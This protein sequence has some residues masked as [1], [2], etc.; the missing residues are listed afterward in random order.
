MNNTVTDSSKP[1]KPFQQRL[2]NL[3]DE[4][5]KQKRFFAVNPDKTPIPK[6]WSNPENQKPYTEIQ[7]YAGFDTTGHDVADD[8]LFLDFDH[9]FN[10]AGK[11][12]NALAEEWYTKIRDALK[13]Y[14]ELSISLRGAHMI[15]IPTAGKFPKIASGKNGRID[16]GDGACLEIFYR[17]KARYCLFTGN[18]LDCEPKA[19]VSHGQ[20]VDDVLQTLLDEVQNKNKKPTTPAR[21]VEPLA[22]LIYS[23]ADAR[24]EKSS[25][26]GTEYDLFRA[27]L[28]LEA[29]NPAALADSDWLAVMTACKNIGVPYAVVDAFNR[30][31]KN[32]YDEQE[33]L[34]RW[35]S[36]SD[37]SFDIATLHGIAKRFGYDEKAARRDYYK[38]H[39]ELTTEISHSPAQASDDED[40]PMGDQQQEN[41]TQDRIK[42]CPVNLRLS[43]NYKFGT[44]GITL[45]IPPKS[46][47]GKTKY[48]PV[49]K[50]P[51][52]PTKIFREPR[53]KHYTYE[54]AILIRGKW[55]TTEIDGTALADPRAIIALAGCGALIDEPKRLCRFLNTMIALNP[56]LKEI[57]AYDQPGWHDDQFIYPTGG[58]DYVVRRAGFNYT[59]IFAKRGDP[60]ILKSY[61]LLG[62][63]RLYI[64]D[65]FLTLVIQH[66]LANLQ[67]FHSAHQKLCQ[68]PLSKLDS[69]LQ[70]SLPR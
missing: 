11:F 66:T 34:K 7:G 44:S 45:I 55:G 46:K 31:D 69:P 3:P 27:G 59:E 20:A 14:C 42:S 25:K 30:R 67:Y 12:V 22:E 4:I 41:W 63:Y 52:V 39:P 35:D 70:A 36:V 13:T 32:R 16:F 61:L 8:Y 68:L 64:F 29:I 47:G 49:T 28:M 37:P 18:V 19:P 5:L 43:D 58:E 65:F 48:I 23:S 56:D 2:E 9:I 50:T 6:G 1:D 10:D 15:A 62:S 26:L 24:D 53:S 57:K 60:D 38:L 21:S 40:R 54:I 17:T 33:N 51:I